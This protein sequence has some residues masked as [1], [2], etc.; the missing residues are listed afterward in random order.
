MPLEVTKITVNLDNNINV[1]VGQAL[2]AGSLEKIRKEIKNNLLMLINKGFFSNLIKNLEELNILKFNEN[3]KKYNNSNIRTQFYGL[4]DTIHYTINRQDDEI[5]EKAFKIQQLLNNLR[6]AVLGVPNIDHSIGIQDQGQYY[7]ITNYMMNTQEVLKAI[8]GTPSL[9]SKRISSNINKTYNTLENIIEKIKQNKLWN[10]LSLHYSNMVNTMLNYSN[11]TPSKVENKWTS[12]IFEKHIQETGE[13]N[14]LQNFSIFQHQ[15]NI[16]A[17]WDDYHATSPAYDL[18]GHKFKFAS[19]TQGGDW[20]ETL[21]KSFILSKLKLGLQKNWSFLGKIDTINLTNL[22]D[23][24]SFW[25]NFEQN[26]SLNKEISDEMIDKILA[27]L[28]SDQAIQKL[29][30]KAIAQLKGYSI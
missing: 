9:N 16:K 2:K 17:L 25:K 5:I 11:P 12:Q 8:S 6:A 13:K 15:W 4:S 22:Q 18:E 19:Q 30:L 3:I 29:G 7:Y 21:V 26:I 20:G 27:I 23:M 10:N 24:F 28:L 14:Q 1:Q